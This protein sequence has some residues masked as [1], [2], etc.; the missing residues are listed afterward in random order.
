MIEQLELAFPPLA[1]RFNIA[2]QQMVPVVR[3]VAP[4]PDAPAGSDRKAGSDR[5]AGSDRKAGYEVANMQWGLVPSWADDPKIGQRMINARSE[6]AA[7]KPSFRSAMRRRRCLVPADGYYE[8]QATGGTKQPYLFHLPHDEDF[9]LA[10]LW[11]RRARE[12]E[13]PLETFTILTTDASPQTAPY[14]DRMPVILPVD[15]WTVWLDPDFAD[16]DHLQSWLK[17][18]DQT[19]EI[20][21][22]SRRVNNPRNEGAEC[23]QAE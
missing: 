5:M 6:T 7:T 3:A 1:P 16:L 8:W 4:S 11:E 13:P 9:A 15:A 10:G 18:T 2:P 17:P 12:G 23:V 14:H 19:L 21:R 22:V 20:D